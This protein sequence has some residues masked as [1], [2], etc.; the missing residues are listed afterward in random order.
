MSRLVGDDLGKVFLQSMNELQNFDELIEARSS[1]DIHS[2]LL[3][4]GHT[5]LYEGNQ[6]SIREL[7][8]DGESV[9]INHPA[10]SLEEWLGNKPH[11]PETFLQNNIDKFIVEFSDLGRFRR[12]GSDL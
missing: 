7:R 9:N 8:R 11:L 10:Q 2:H 4:I 3:N 12:S 5:R 1:E 6:E